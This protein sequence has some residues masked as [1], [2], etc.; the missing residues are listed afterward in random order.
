MKEK[1]KS[2]T[3]AFSMQPITLTI[4]EPDKRSAFNPEND[5]KEIKQEGKQ[6]NE[7]K[8]INIYVGYDFDG[9]KIFEYIAETVNVHYFN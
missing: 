2:I 7:N 8:M 9:N 3:E 5:I 1:I 6:V 4:T